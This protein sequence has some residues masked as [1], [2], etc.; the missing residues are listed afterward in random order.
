MFPVIRMII[1]PFPE[2]GLALR[3]APVA[4]LTPPRLSMG[5]LQITSLEDAWM[6]PLGICGAAPSSLVL[7]KHPAGT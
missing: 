3:V 4:F 5:L 7:W 6:L 1:A 2:R